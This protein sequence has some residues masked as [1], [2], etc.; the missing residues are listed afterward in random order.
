MANA[1]LADRCGWLAGTR[2]PCEQGRHVTRELG[3]LT[4]HRA[5]VLAQEVA[6]LRAE[7]LSFRPRAFGA[8]GGGSGG[9]YPILLLSPRPVKRLGTAK[10][11]TYFDQVVDVVGGLEGGHTTLRDLYGLAAHGAGQVLPAPGHGPLQAGQAEHVQAIRN[12]LRLEEGLEADG[13]SGQLDDLL[14]GHLR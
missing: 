13:A 14:D 9:G 7:V 3:P 2:N 10:G 5:A 8:G 1:D 11:F 4:V 6:A 12:S